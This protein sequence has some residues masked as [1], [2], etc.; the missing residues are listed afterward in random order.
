MQWLELKVPP[1]IAA[2]LVGAAMWGVAHR[3][4]AV[5]LTAPLR[6]TVAVVCAA[7]GLIVALAGFLAFRRA[8]TAV[9]PIHPEAASTVVMGGIYKYTRNPMYVGLSAV[10]TGWAIWL[11]VPWVFLGPVALMLFLARFQIIPEERVMSSKF[12]RDYDE[13]RER[14]R[15]W[16]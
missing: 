14:V 5:E 6:F 2:V 8:K 16:L 9:S 11:S 3:L 10:L 12:G 13:Y 1:P 4:A 15:R 7:L